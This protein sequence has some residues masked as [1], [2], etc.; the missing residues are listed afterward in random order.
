MDT[1]AMHHY[2]ITVDKIRTEVRLY[3]D[4]AL[5]E[6]VVALST[7]LDVLDLDDLGYREDV[8]KAVI[9]AK[10]DRYNNATRYYTGILGEI[11]FNQFPL[12]EAKALQ[13]FEATQVV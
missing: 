5:V 1:G 3:V 11:S 2:L 7:L 9:G 4:G 12:S 13:H 6:T 10:I 8:Y